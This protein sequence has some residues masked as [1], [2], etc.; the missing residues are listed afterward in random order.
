MNI[1]ER[2]VGIPESL[3][4][5]FN[6]DL[7][8]TASRYTRARG[9]LSLWTMG[10]RLS[11]FAILFFLN[12]FD[13]MSQI[14]A[15]I[16]DHPVGQSI[17]FFGI[18]FIGTDLLSIP[19]Q[20]YAVFGIEQRFGFN[21][22]TGTVFMI[23]KLKSW[24]LTIIIGGGIFWVLAEIYRAMPDQFWILAWGV[25]VLFIMLFTMFYSNVFVPLFN[26]QSPLEPGVLRDAIEL[27]A[28]RHGFSLKN[29]F[30]ING[31]KRSTKANAYFTGI[32]PKKRIVLYDTLIEKLSAEEIVSVLA[33]EIGHYKNKHVAVGFLISALLNLGVMYLLNLLLS[34]PSLASSLGMEPS[35]HASLLVFVF[36]LQPVSTLAGVFSN[37]I[38]RQHEYAADRFACKQVNVSVFKNALVKLSVDHLSHPAP[39]PWYVIV[40]YSHPPL[41]ERLKALDVSA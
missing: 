2:H 37:L 38:S 32:G 4:A 29:I 1:K 19:F 41:L 25:L 39:H 23:D 31:S 35:L 33:H 36:L 26:K 20:W 6:P 5:Y 10:F 28:S 34:F 13:V 22:T 24:I 40:N 11:L 15:V 7:L 14:A 9:S 30:V 12:G 27:F 16:W 18:V 8:K 3:S 17:V 21:K